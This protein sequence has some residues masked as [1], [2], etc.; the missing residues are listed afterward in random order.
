M[1]C[2]STINVQVSNPDS[3]ISSID[4]ILTFDSG[5]LDSFNFNVANSEYNS[6]IFNTYE[7]NN[8]IGKDTRKFGGTR[9]SDWPQNTSIKNV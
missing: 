3:P 6:P 8:T 9:L 5:S 1:F 2:P 4:M 7:F